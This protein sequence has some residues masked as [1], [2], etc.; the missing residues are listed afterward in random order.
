MWRKKEDLMM[1][2][3]YY[4]VVFSAIGLT[5]ILIYFVIGSPI[6]MFTEGE[7]IEDFMNFTISEKILRELELSWDESDG[8]EYS[9]CLDGEYHNEFLNDNPLNGTRNVNINVYKN[10]INSNLSTSVAVDCHDTI[11]YLHNHPK[12]EGKERCKLSGTDIKHFQDSHRKDGTLFS[13]VQCDKRKFVV[14]A[15]FAKGLPL[16]YSP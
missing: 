9:I 8:K 7:P 5:I 1:Y 14:H 10:I 2:I 3:A 13:I 4:V 16:Y 11:A 15:W 6:I 12:V